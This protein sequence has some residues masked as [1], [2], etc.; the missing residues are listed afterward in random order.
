MRRRGSRIPERMK[1]MKIAALGSCCHPAPCPSHGQ[2]GTDLAVVI[3][4]VHT[5][6]DHIQQRVHQPLAGSH[7]LPGFLPRGAQVPKWAET[8]EPLRSTPDR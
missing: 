1:G 5:R 7:L 6:V 8:W 2:A 3:G 4:C